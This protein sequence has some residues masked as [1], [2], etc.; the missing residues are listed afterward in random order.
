MQEVVNVEQLT[1]VK[2]YGEPLE[3]GCIYDIPVVQLKE[4]NRIILEKNLV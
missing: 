1:L 3:I 2:Y 4:L